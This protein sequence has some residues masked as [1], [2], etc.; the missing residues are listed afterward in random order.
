MLDNF[1]DVTNNSHITG[2]DGGP[3]GTGGDAVDTNGF[4]GSGGAGGD[5]GVGL[6]FSVLTGIS[7]KV[8]ENKQGASISGGKGGDAGASGTSPNGFNTGDGVG[9]TGGTGIIASGITINNAGTITGGDG[10]ADP[11]TGQAGGRDGVGGVGISG[12]ALIINNASTGVISGGNAGIGAAGNPLVIGGTAI[13]GTYNSG[14]GTTIVNAGRISAGKN[15]QGTV[16]P[17]AIAIQF[18]GNQNVMEIQPGSVLE[19]TIRAPDT[20]NTLRLGGDVGTDQF[21]LAQLVLQYSVFNAYEK[22]GKSTWT[23]TG[24]I[25]TGQST[26]WTLKEGE[27]AV[28]SAAKLG[29][30]GDTLTF[31]GGLLKVTGTTFT[32]LAGTV[33]P[34]WGAGGGGFD[35][36]DPTNT[37]VLGTE[38][39]GFTGGPLTKAGPGTL[40]SQVLGFNFKDL[41]LLGG[42]YTGIYASGLAGDPTGLI[43]LNGGVFQLIGNNSQPWGPNQ[44]WAI[45]PN[46]GGIDMATAGHILT[47]NMPITQSGASAGVLTKDGPGTL[48]LGGAN[49]ND[50]LTIYNGVVSVKAA[51][52]IGVGGLTF[53]SKTVAA[54]TSGTLQTTDTII[55]NGAV[56]FDAAGTFD[57]GPAAANSLTLA[58]DIGGGN[59]LTKIGPG[60]LILTGTNDTAGSGFSGTMD[61]QSGNLAVGA[62]GTTGTLGLG[63]S[64]VSLATGSNLTFNRSNAYAYAGKITGLGSID[65][66]G[67]PN[68]VTT[69]SGDN[70][71]KGTTTVTSGTLMIDGDQTNAT[72]ATEVKSGGTLGGTGTIG[73]NV[74]VDGNGTL[75]S[76]YA[77]GAG[78][79]LTI[80]GALDFQASSIMDFNYK[81]DPGGSGDWDAAQIQVTGGNIV[82]DSNAVLNV[83]VDSGVTLTPGNYGL[84]Q[85]TTGTRTG[86][87][88]PGA[89]PANFVVKYDIANEVYLTVPAATTQTFN[90]WDGPNTTWTGSVKGGS[91]T[92]QA[93]TALTN[94]SDPSAGQNGGFTDKTFAMF[95]GTA[96]SSSAPCTVTV[97]NSGGA[98]NVGGMQFS[99]DGY[100][101]TG[102]VLTLWPTTGAAANQSVIKVGYQAGDEN[103]KAT[104]GSQLVDAPG[105]AIQLV[106]DQAGIL[107]LTNTSN[108]YS[109]GTLLDQG[110]LSVGDDGNLG[111]GGAI[112]FRGGILQVTGTSFNSTAR[113]INWTTSGGGYDI[114]DANNTFTLSQTQTISGAAPFVKKGA[115]TLVFTGS[116]EQFEGIMSVQQGTLQVGNGG[117]TGTLGKSS[118][119]VSLE[120]GSTLKFNRS[121]FYTYSGK[122]TGNGG[123]DQAGGP[124]SI[125]TLVNDNDYKGTTT[126]SSGALLI[127]GDQSNATGATTVKSGGTL[128]GAGTIGGAVTIN[129]GGTLYSQDEL[130]FSINKLTLKSTL[131]LDANSNTEFYYNAGGPVGTADALQIQVG[132]L[133]TIDPAAKLNVKLG[134]GAT[135][136]PGIYGLIES[137]KP[138]SGE[139]SKTDSSLPPNTFVQYHD[140]EYQVNLYVPGTSITPTTHNFWDGS[141]TSAN[142]QIDGG[143]GTWQAASPGGLTNW[144]NYEGT[145]NGGFT[146]KT[147]TIFQTQGGEVTL[148][149]SKGSIDVA[150]MQFTVDGYV[151]RG[152]V[153]T[154]WPSP[155]SPTSGVR[156]IIRTG[157]NTPDS[158]D[159]T[160]V[161]ES[162]LINAPG[163][164]IQLVK[165]DLG[166]LVLTNDQNSYSGG[167]VFDG[168]T[169]SV[170]SDGNL[171]AATGELTFD[172]GIMQVTG[173]KYRSTTRAIKWE[174]E[175]GGFDIADKDNIFT[176]SASQTLSGP[177]GLLKRGAGTL[178]MSGA[179]SYTGDTVVEGGTLQ[180]AAANVFSSAS[181]F[182]VEQNGALA[183]GGF[184]QSLAS[185]SNAGDV[186]LQGTA[187]GTTLTITGDYTG[188]G[189]VVSLN[190]AL[191]DDNSK[192]DRLVV[193]G[194]TS[195]TSTLV[196][197]NVG[198]TGDQTQ[199]QGIKVIEV[200]GNSNGTFKLKGDYVYHG[201]QAVTAGAYAY[202]LFKGSASAATGGTASIAAADAIDESDWYLRSVLKGSV[203]PQYQPGVPIYEAYSSVLQELNAVGTLRQRVGNRYWSG[204]ANPA[205]AQGDSEGTMV[206][207]KEAGADIASDTYIWGR[208]EGAHGR[209]EPRYSTSATRYNVNTY[210]LETGIDGKLYETAQGAVIGGVTMHYGY[211]KAN[212]GSVHG[213]GGVDANGYGFGGTL[214][215]YGDDGV[216]VDAVAQTTWYTNDLTSDTA[217]RS[218]ASDIDGFGYALSLEA[219]K[220]V[221]IDPNW[222]ITPQA[223]LTWSAIQFDGFTDSFGAHVTHDETD[224]LKGRLGIAADYGQAWRDEQGLL[225]QANLYAIAN[226]SYEFSKAT[227]IK[228]AGVPFATQND[229]YWGGLGAGGTYSW[230]DGKYA[231]YGEATIDTS[232]EHFADSYRLSG[233]LGFRV[234]W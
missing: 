161:I 200:D 4:S 211:A 166:T 181:A 124:G 9:G 36:D 230:A 77:G 76:Q 133:V 52:N 40:Q 88:K 63:T 39:Q 183:T 190:T 111:N 108:S 51:N 110:T 229:R 42:V 82:I 3:G 28:D 2:G 127:N 24:A 117:T 74:T 143:S 101:V 70:D 132:D 30:V 206:P 46:G 196:V 185:L 16:Y 142:N 99:V 43:T 178:V 120:A 152:G 23:L 72:G 176:L 37:F 106:K 173:E 168:G 10:G 139:F 156:S 191:G 174:E 222:S 97:D 18:T 231:F 83:K 66:A 130:G 85:A 209:F 137:T 69:L 67:G 44:P 31:D 227:K 144:T 189:G 136:D 121:D 219:G 210:G 60:D 81:A 98:I 228:V 215:W 203:T 187:P 233:N 167:T 163:R 64:T 8:L 33:T 151:L 220:R 155:V 57:V 26:P 153:I 186:S 216:Y 55:Y 134:P 182:T 6:Y 145:N 38:F 192:T 223:Q 12:D 141:T 131:T 25:P 62:G 45:G 95:E 140:T 188:Q 194:N 96:C 221:A 164:H 17:N 91:G 109:G 54:P 177:G 87:F 179:N 154:L 65:Q 27:L 147:F 135:F 225:T 198:G 29:Q 214:T 217:R 212:M 7:N 47:I 15:T 89:I 184:D 104:I 1:V 56:T 49:Q 149:M 169:L 100:E 71:Y 138:I 86:Q 172:G 208:V 159:M 5:G 68:S 115:G 58:G 157:M 197:N 107:V 105:Q 13:T 207:A 21:D 53:D 119:I 205:V 50:G 80:K 213:Y 34:V 160:T 171:G 73:G 226:L 123:I 118:S 129:G 175:G 113:Q 32:S 20:N 78:G 103:K 202:R 112:T 75:T 84:L 218:L 116:N 146:D 114:A 11:Y 126:V 170:S 193:K 48:V 122:I 204:A 148:D 94:W 22:V 92:W 165:A 14:R 201:D 150:G 93:G 102:G 79:K 195:G 199:Q 224:S 128:R 180:A 41:N 162:Q 59:D 158:A 234:K 90:Y 61:I 125:T 232:L 35:I 19:G